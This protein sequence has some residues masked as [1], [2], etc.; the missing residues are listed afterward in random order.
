MLSQHTASRGI[1]CV[2]HAVGLVRRHPALLWFP[3]LGL[4]GIGITFVA[5]LRFV[6]E[7]LGLVWW[8]RGTGLV[9]LVEVAAIGGWYICAAGTLTAMNAALIHETTEALD[10]NSPSVRAG[11]EAVWA[12][13]R[14]LSLVAVVTGLFWL[15]DQLL[16]RHGSLPGRIASVLANIAWG[17]V[18]FFLIPVA[19]DTRSSGVSI[20]SESV[21]TFRSVWGEALTA[22][23]GLG[24]VALIGLA[25]TGP[26]YLLATSVL[27]GFAGQFTTVLLALYLAGLSVLGVT[28]IGVTRAALYRY[29]T[30]G[31]LAWFDSTTIAEMAITETNATSEA[32]ASPGQYDRTGQ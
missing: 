2:R 18:S 13:R 17:A 22:S 6:Y 23:F 26:L 3:I 27:G 30:T 12:N 7:L 24:F 16:R 28:T 25:P 19:L 31:E 8:A 14:A 9:R 11:F 1:S 5:G 15:L 21:E 29:A 32:S 10:G 4:G 20:F